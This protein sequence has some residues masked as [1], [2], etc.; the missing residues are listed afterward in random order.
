MDTARTYAGAARAENTQKAYASDWRDFNSWCLDHGLE[1]LPAEPQTLSLF[2]TDRAATLKPSTLQR[3]LTAISQA[4]QRAGHRLDTRHPAVREVWAG[5]RL[6]PWVD[7][8]LGCNEECNREP[9][10]GDEARHHEISLIHPL[11]Q[12]EAQLADPASGQ[13]DTE[14]LADHQSDEDQPSTTRAREKGSRASAS[15]PPAVE[16]VASWKS[17][18][19]FKIRQYDILHPGRPRARVYR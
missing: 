17:W 19:D 11:R 14:G 4:H 8:G 10:G 7:E 6:E 5:I 9:K 16:A 3:R 12:R 1:P 2:L 15:V 18:H 13:P